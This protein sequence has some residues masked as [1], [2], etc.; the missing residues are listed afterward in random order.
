MSYNDNSFTWRH[1]A[2]VIIVVAMICGTIL[3]FFGFVF[4]AVGDDRE[5]RKINRD[6]QMQLEEQRLEAC[7]KEG[8]SPSE[9]AFCMW[10]LEHR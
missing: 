10:H 9:V 5:N 4:D 2:V 6:Q 7:E 8:A 3:G 1:V